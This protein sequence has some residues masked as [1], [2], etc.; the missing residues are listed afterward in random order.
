[1]R[2]ESVNGRLYSQV[3]PAPANLVFARLSEDLS[4]K[5][6]GLH[7]RK[8]FSID[9]AVRGEGEVVYKKIHCTYT[10]T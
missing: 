3:S 6:A 8:V 2:V 9:N 10:H 5:A 1:M 7:D 4:A